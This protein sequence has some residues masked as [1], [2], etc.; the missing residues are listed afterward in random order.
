M[1]ALEFWTKQLEKSR[2]LQR[3]VNQALKKR[4]KSFSLLPKLKRH[5]ED[6]IIHLCGKP[7]TN[8]EIMGLLT[9]ELSPFW[10]QPSPFR[11]YH[12]QNTKAAK[13]YRRH[14]KVFKKRSTEKLNERFAERVAIVKSMKEVCRRRKKFLRD[15]AVIYGKERK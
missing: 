1:N 3:E 6:G 13:E 4:N 8:D 7:E 10:F 5:E 2:Q 12:N 9:R 11:P 15:I 14:M